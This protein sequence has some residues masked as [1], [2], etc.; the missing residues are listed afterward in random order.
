MSINVEEIVTAVAI[1]AG[2]LAAAH[3][4]DRILRRRTNLPPAALTRYRALRRT[5]YALILVIGVAMAVFVFPAVRG[6]A[7]GL[8]TSAAVLGVIVGIAAQ[9]SL[10]NFFSGL[11]LAFAQPVRIGDRIEFRGVSGVVED[12]GRVYTRVRTPD[13]AWL[14][15]PNNLLASDTIRNWTIVD[16]ECTAEVRLL[17]PLSADLRKAMEMVLE[18]ARAVPGALPGREPTVRVESLTAGADGTKA[19]LSVGVWARDHGAAAGVSSDLRLRLDQRLQAA[20]V[21]TDA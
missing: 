1:L 11:V 12:V 4:V 17:V 19:E 20:G 18:E 7:G 8:I 5:I 9:S 3:V 21:F 15:V 10:G 2:A 14:L 16:P 13:G 6:V